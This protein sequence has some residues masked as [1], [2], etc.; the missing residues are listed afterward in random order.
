MTIQAE[1][2]VDETLMAPR[3][4]RPLFWINAIIA[5]C[6][7]VLS[8]LLNFTGYYNDTLDPSKPSIIGNV[9]NG[10]DS[11]LER[12]F[13]W[14]TYFT[15]LSNIVVAVVLTVL[16]L[17]R[18][19]F[20]HTDRVGA[21]WRALRLDS[22]LMIVIT[23]VVYNLLLAE[24]PKTGWDLVNNSLEHIITPIVTL[25]VWLIAG[26]RGLI[27]IRVIGLSMIL[28]LLWA[29]GALL[30]G[31]AIGSYPYSFLDVSSDGLV[32]VLVF[33]AMIMV[34][35]LI[36]AFALLGLDALFRRMSAGI[37]ARG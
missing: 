14:L 16:V 27:N 8:F 37:R 20:A 29:G 9:A 6:G 13:D 33:I 4:A 36:L 35:A 2:A 24:G 7:V 12:F 18:G 17:R 21:T 15:V 25:L 10:I 34:V 22:I 19:Y 32:S 28:P 3:Y 5:W 1:V 26:P 31:A 30:R 11:P 23:G